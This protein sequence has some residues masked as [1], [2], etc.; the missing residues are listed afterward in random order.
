[1][2]IQL[3]FEAGHPGGKKLRALTNSEFCRALLFLPGIP[4]SF[5][6]IYLLT[7]N[8]AVNPISHDA[9]ARL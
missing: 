5:N 7:R 2:L 9:I 3:H 8:Q 4:N 6:R 1:M